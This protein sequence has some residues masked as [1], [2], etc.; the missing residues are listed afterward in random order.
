MLETIKYGFATEGKDITIAKA[1]LLK[2][3]S[4]A[5]DLAFPDGSDVGKCYL[6]MGVLMTNNTNDKDVV[7]VEHL[8]LDTNN[9]GISNY[10][11]LGD[12]DSD[13]NELKELQNGSYYYLF[14]HW[15]NHLT[16]FVADEEEE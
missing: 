7:V 15:L 8:S 13:Q 1:N 12:K 3:F 16:D 14:N 10:V 4:G 9:V 5:L 6:E 11:V 2:A